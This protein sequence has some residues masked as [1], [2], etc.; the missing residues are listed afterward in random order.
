MN[1]HVIVRSR[2]SRRALRCW[3]PGLAKRDLRA[4]RSGR[5]RRPGLGI[6]LTDA[7]LH[8]LEIQDQFSVGLADLQARHR[9][10]LPAA[11]A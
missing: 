8:A 11:F 5:I 4:R 6:G 9:G 1:L 7:T 3:R 2:R 10:A